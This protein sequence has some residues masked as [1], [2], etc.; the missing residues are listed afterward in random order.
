[1]PEVDFEAFFTKDARHHL[2]N[3]V[4]AALEEDGPDYT[5]LAIF[6]SYKN[7]TARLIA[8]QNATIAGMPIV[9]IILELTAEV[10]DHKNLPEWQWTPLHKDGDHVKNGD[11]LGHITGPARLILRA[12]R[13]I[14]NFLT[15]LSGIAT[16][17]SSYVKALE[18][19]GIVLLDTRKTLP[20]LRYPEKYA[21]KVGGGRNHRCTLAE[22][23]LLKNNHIDAI[24][25]IVPAVKKI[26][27]TYTPC[28]PIE[29]ECRNM[30]EVEEALSAGVERIM[31][32]NMDKEALNEALLSIP[33]EIEVEISGGVN[34]EALSD[35]A[36]VSK[37]KPNFI[38]VGRLTHSA[39][40]ADISLHY[41]Y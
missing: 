19:T 36:K 13:I 6:D 17:T 32:D 24:G 1:M 10:I 38:S 12:E 8:K 22:M 20:G 28:P 25:G 39:P 4:A 23:I 3:A 33:N 14:L 29:V 26:K 21:V 35:L 15:H 2:L 27:E 7:I 37:R 9:P 18:S 40:S 16:L 34:L 5:T 41:E 30:K 11:I 31:L